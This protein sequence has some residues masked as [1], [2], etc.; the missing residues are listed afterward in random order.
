MILSIIVPVYNIQE[1]IG[2]CL[3]SLLEQNVNKG[4]YEIIAVD[5]GSTDN[6]GNILDKYAER[7][8][9]VHV[10]HK[11]NG[12]VSSARNIAL[13]F[14]KGD[15]IWFVDGDDLVVPNI[16]G[17]IFENLKNNDYPDLM[18]V[19]VRSFIDGEKI[20]SANL[21]ELSEETSKYDDWI[22][23]WLINRDII[24]KSKIR[25]DEDV[26]LGEDDIFCVFVRRHIKRTVKFNRIVYL[27]RQ[28]EGSALHSSLTEE[29]FNKVIKSHSASLEYAKKYDYFWYKR[30]MVYNR[31]PYIMIF[32]AEKPFIQSRIY[33]NKLKEY[34]LFPLPKQAQISG[35]GGLKPRSI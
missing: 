32:I 22:P 17:E 26:T 9:N 31:M 30:D 34:G 5:D 14:A 16:L 12:G 18:Y 1:H 19:K 6:S 29:N 28:R 23:A 13:D 27:Y 21:D 20:L 10:Y 2:E 7:Y 25:F 15:Y 3:D 35:G 33:I 8:S 11:S 4:Q 24:E